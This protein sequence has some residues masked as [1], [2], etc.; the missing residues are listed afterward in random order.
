MFLQFVPHTSR[1]PPVLGK[2]QDV[3]FLEYVMDFVTCLAYH[4]MATGI[5]PAIIVL[6]MFMQMFEEIGKI[7]VGWLVGWSQRRCP[8]RM[9]SCLWANLVETLVDGRVSHGYPCY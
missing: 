9:L 8:D 3:L 6:N 1:T 4:F 5:F 2:L 7:M